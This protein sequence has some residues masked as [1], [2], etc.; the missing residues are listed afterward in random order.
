LFTRIGVLSFIHMKMKNGSPAWYSLGHAVLVLVYISSVAWLMTNAETILGE[1]EETFLIPV[2]M[3]M[4]L[5]LSAAVMGLL[6]F[7]RPIL[8][9]LDGKKREAVMF[10]GYTLGWLTLL[11]FLVFIAL[12]VT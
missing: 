10:L 3:L 5:V 8:M 2:A 1:A 7:G 12:A 9:Y 6:V 4:L 11:T